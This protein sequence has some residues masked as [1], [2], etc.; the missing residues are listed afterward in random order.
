[1]NWRYAT[2]SN[3]ASDI[4]QKMTPTY[5]YASEQTGSHQTFPPLFRAI[6]A[7]FVGIFLIIRRSLGIGR[8]NRQKNIVNN[9]AQDKI[10]FQGIFLAMRKRQRTTID[11]MRDTMKQLVKEL[12]EEMKTAVKS[13][14]E[15]PWKV[16]DLVGVD[17]KLISSEIDQLEEVA[18]RLE[19]IS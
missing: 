7:I 3:E 13:T 18:K 4:L 15:R 14:I 9:R 2:E 1:M 17:M 19:S 5:R 11:K 8:F 16:E 6:K 12:V 10:I